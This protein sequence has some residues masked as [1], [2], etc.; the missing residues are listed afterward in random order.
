M[1]ATIYLL[2]F[3]TA[4]SA[5]FPQVPTNH[6]VTS[7]K[8][9]IEL[10]VI[11]N[12]IVGHNPATKKSGFIWPRGSNAQYLYGG[13]FILLKDQITSN[14]SY[15]F[16]EYSYNFWDATSWFVPGSISDGDFLD[17]NKE[18]KYRVYS[19][20]NYSKYSGR[21]FSDQNAPKWPIWV[22]NN[23]LGAYYGD[24][25]VDEAERTRS[26]SK[27]LFKSDEDIVAIYKD[28][29]TNMNTGSKLY[30][31]DMPL[32]IEAETRVYSYE[33]D[34]QK[35]VVFIN[36][37]ITNKTNNDIGG[38]SF[39]PVFDID[40]TKITNAF[41]GIDNDRMIF[42]ENTSYV[43][44]ATEME[45]Y[46]EGEE[47]GYISFQWV[48]TPLKNGPIID[49]S[50]ESNPQLEVYG[51]RQLPANFDYD[52][53][54]IFLLFGTYDIVKVADQRFFMPTKLFSLLPNQS[55]SFVIQI[56][57]TPPNEDYPNMD[58][59]TRKKI[60]AELLANETFFKDR[61]TSVELSEEQS[62]I[63]VYP[64]PTK[65]GKISLEL[66]LPIGEQMTIELFDLS[67]NALATL[68]Q[69]LHSNQQY[70]LNLG[71]KPVGTYLLSITIG[72]KKY[73]KK[74]VV[75]E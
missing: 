42:L 35:N 30:E 49:Y 74:F 58:D 37:I 10:T 36:W 66:D 25:K 75:S 32:G 70:E 63:A 53:Y 27:P 52:V 7:T 71:K 19:S 6:S 16:P 54:S 73:S 44:F 60:E 61:L 2:A 51:L 56:N 31:L 33:N 55:A 40:I 14:L 11:N 62:P 64:N 46:E 15:F 3:I 38:L 13:G 12:G 59:E 65:D 18:S 69:G 5:V 9:N 8:G 26:L 50:N 67:G 68:Y 22:D 21:D 23:Y 24:Y 41:T 34:D 57:M 17:T 43:S 47:F 20:T 1:K 48:Q 39:A 4:L 72:D 45:E 29:D 28:T